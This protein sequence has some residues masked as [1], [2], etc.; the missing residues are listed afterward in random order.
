M[1]QDYVVDIIS[2]NAS[3][4]LVKTLYG[5]LSI[6]VTFAISLFTRQ[7]FVKVEKKKRQGET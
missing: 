5:Y 7:Q 6:K 2:F 1:Y 3:S 4:V